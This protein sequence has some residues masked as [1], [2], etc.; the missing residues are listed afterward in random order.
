MG[1]RGFSKLAVPDA[2]LQVSVKGGR[3]QIE[4]EGK[5]RKFLDHV[6]HVTFSGD[7]AMEREQE[8]LYITERRLCLDLPSN[9]GGRLLSRAQQVQR[10]LPSDVFCG[11]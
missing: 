10:L 11:Q 2:C 8:V 3:L 7:Y 4:Q 9:F 6:E 5:S 1:K